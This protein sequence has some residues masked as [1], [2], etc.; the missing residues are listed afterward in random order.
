MAPC[1]YL[2]RRT[3]HIVISN[4]SQ[5]SVSVRRPSTCRDRSWGAALHPRPPSE[6]GQTWC[7]PLAR[8]GRPYSGTPGRQRLPWPA[9]GPIPPR[10]NPGSHS[11]CPTEEMT[12]HFSVS[13]PHVAVQLD[14]RLPPWCYSLDAEIA[15]SE[16][17]TTTRSL[18]YSGP[19]SRCQ[20]M[21]LSALLGSGE[22]S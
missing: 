15:R 21:A 20:F 3:A 1:G 5:Q 6:I 12:S 18:C 10:E 19:V 16:R 2:A 9:V 11:R 8:A 13:C 7:R 17:A 4:V 22:S 14:L